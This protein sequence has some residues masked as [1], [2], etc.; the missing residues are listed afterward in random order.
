M[1]YFR[2]NNFDALGPIFTP[3]QKSLASLYILAVSQWYEIGLLAEEFKEDILLANQ[4]LINPGLSEN[5]PPNFWHQEVKNLVAI[6]ILGTIYELRTYAINDPL[7]YKNMVL[8]DAAATHATFKMVPVVFIVLLGLSIM[9][10][11]VLIEPLFSRI[12]MEFPATQAGAIAWNL[13]GLVQLFR[14]AM[15]STGIVSWDN[16]LIGSIPTTQ[17]GMLMAVPDQHAGSRRVG[18]RL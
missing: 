16:G 7:C 10:L 5:L 2:N 3:I 11:S 12:F 9:I 13:N 15:E 1:N 14:L 6:G 17:N 18:E 4:K 8:I